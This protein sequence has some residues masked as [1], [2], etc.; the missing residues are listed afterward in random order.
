MPVSG[1]SIMLAFPT[2]C[3]VFGTARKS[4]I[5]LISCSLAKFCVTSNAGAL[6][7]P[8]GSSNTIECIFQL[9]SN[10]FVWLFRIGA[11]LSGDVQHPGGQ[12]SRIPPRRR[13]FLPV[14]AH[15]RAP[16]RWRIQICT[17]RRNRLSRHSAHDRGN[18]GGFVRV[19]AAD[20]GLS[21]VDIRRYKPRTV[22]FQSRFGLRR[23]HDKDRHQDEQSRE[24]RGS[25]SSN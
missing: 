21:L 2:A 8:R 18:D 14:P 17:G 5:R 13:R 24:C 10:P 19:Q 25:T 1:P 4:E 11:G 6:S 12:F 20:D 7:K 16:R 23:G 9:R 15:R 3:N 22:I